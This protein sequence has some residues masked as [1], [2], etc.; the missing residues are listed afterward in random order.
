MQPDTQAALGS[1]H[2]CV[3]QD[4]EG[5]ISSADAE[6]QPSW[7]QQSA[8]WLLRPPQRQ[9]LDAQSTAVQLAGRLGGSRDRHAVLLLLL[10]AC[11]ICLILCLPGCT[12]ISCLCAAGAGAAVLVFSTTDRASFE[13][14]PAWKQKVSHAKQQ[15]AGQHKPGCNTGCT[16]ARVLSPSRRP[17]RQSLQ[18]CEQS[19]GHGPARSRNTCSAPASA[20]Q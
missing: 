3:H 17:L 10:S 11:G 13:A 12:E 9:Q 19:L 2:C 8:R 4:P 1:G 15:P 14:V 6:D 16:A 7:H 20:I 5:A 18:W